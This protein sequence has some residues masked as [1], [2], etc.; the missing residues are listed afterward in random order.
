MSLPAWHEEPI[1]KKHNRGAFDCGEPTLNEFLQR[2]ARKNHDLGG[3]KTFLAISDADNS[4][5]L[6][7][8]SLSPAS[9]EYARTP[10]IVRR[11]LARYDLP[12][13]RLAR[14]AVDRKLQGQGLGGQ[15]LL[16]AGRRCLLAAAE[17]GGVALLI[18]AKNEKVAGWY[19]GYGAVPLADAPLSL[20]LP[21]ATIQTV[22]KSVGKY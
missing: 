7:F 1:S 5:I 21:L 8:Y 3:A 12:V 17:V 9:V 4:T 14:L 22:L 6:G 20:L 16:T 2:H 10:E 11:G 19:A 15:I 13:F 18:D